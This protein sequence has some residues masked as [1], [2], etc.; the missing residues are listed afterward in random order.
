MKSVTLAEAK[1]AARELADQVR[2][3]PHHCTDCHP[4]RPCE[5]LRAMRAELADRRR[6]VRTWFDPPP[7]SPRLFDV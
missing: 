1:A 6:S 5:R 4:R 7:D 3:H 2:T